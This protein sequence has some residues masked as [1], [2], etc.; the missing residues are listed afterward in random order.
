MQK[1]R[2]QSSKKSNNSLNNR[3]TGLLVPPEGIQITIWCISLSFSAETNTPFTKWKMLTTWWPP[4]F[5]LIPDWLKPGDWWLRF[6]K[7]Q[8]A[9]SP[10]TNQKNMHEL[11][12]H[13]ATLITYVAFNNPWLKAIRE[14]LPFENQLPMLLAWHP[15]LSLTTT[16]CQDWLCCTWGEET[17]F[18]FGNSKIHYEDLKCLIHWIWFWFRV[19]PLFSLLLSSWYREADTERDILQMKI[20]FKNVNYLHK[21]V[22]SLFR[23]PPVSADSQEKWLKIILM[24][25]RHIWGGLFCYL[26][27]SGGSM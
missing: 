10:P 6:P 22:T 25:K 21:R 11:I 17:L 13:P 7:H 1:Q 15:A 9:I 5:W 24:P 16:W 27:F 3:V 8:P 20:F 4:A 2:K 14:F 12:M 26:G 19:T 18:Q 23:A